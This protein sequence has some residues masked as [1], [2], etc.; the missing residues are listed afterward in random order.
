MYV[1]KTDKIFICKV[2]PWTLK[3]HTENKC[4]SPRLV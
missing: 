4:L 1:E 2:K 3:E